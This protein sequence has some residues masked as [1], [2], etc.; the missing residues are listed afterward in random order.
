MTYAN[1]LSERVNVEPDGRAS[2][3]R[4]AIA[5]GRRN[6]V[7]APHAA[8]G[9]RCVQLRQSRL[10]LCDLR[11]WWQSGLERRHMHQPCRALLMA[12]AGRV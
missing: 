6:I 4:V 7:L 8:H 11:W 10:F 5:G 12:S 1:F 3:V 9:N 2:T